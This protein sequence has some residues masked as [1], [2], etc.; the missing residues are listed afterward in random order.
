DEWRG[1]REVYGW[2]EPASPRRLVSRLRGELGALR[3]EGAGAAALT[4][5][6]WSELCR[7]AAA[8]L[9]SRAPALP[10]SLRRR[11]SLEGRGR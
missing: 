7:Y 10:E 2:V 8:V 11:M 4:A 9:G 1:L 5:A 6:G 3:R